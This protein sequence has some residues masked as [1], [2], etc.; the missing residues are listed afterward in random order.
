MVS[1][2]T[3]QNIV[4]A[5]WTKQYLASTGEVESRSI[6]SPVVQLLRKILPAFISEAILPKADIFAG[7][8]AVKRTIIQLH[9]ENPTAEAD[10][11]TKA[12]EKINNLVTY[13]A[14][15]Q[16]ERS[17]GWMEALID[18]KTLIA[19]PTS[20]RVEEPVVENQ[21]VVEQPVLGAPTPSNTQS[22]PEDEQV[23]VPTTPQ[24]TQTVATPLHDDLP[25]ILDLP[26]LPE[27]QE[28]P[29]QREGIQENVREIED[30]TPAEALKL[31][32]I[33]EANKARVR[34]EKRQARRA[35]KAAEK[36]AKKAAEAQAKATA[37]SA[38]KKPTS[39]KHRT[40]SSVTKK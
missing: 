16:P 1:R 10:L 24:E 28:V 19:I 26:K 17:A 36:T 13:F 32:A 34:E 18:V 27:E 14:T 20:T 40:D 11:L 3:L 15:K 5:D 21:P 31:A 7:A 2:V 8:D 39:R 29:V 9:A 25:D 6:F 35:E 23:V 33:E 12:A 4:D 37:A 22:T 38:P 30:P